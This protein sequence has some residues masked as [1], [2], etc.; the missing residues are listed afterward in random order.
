MDCGIGCSNGNAIEPFIN[1]YADD[2]KILLLDVSEPMLAECRKRFG[3]ADIRNYDISQGLPEEVDASLILS[4]LTLQFTSIEY[5]Q[6]IVQSVYDRREQAERLF[7]LKRSS[8][9]RTK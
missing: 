2:C 1:T 5:R 6:K 8:A 4:V 7:S 9:I 3:N